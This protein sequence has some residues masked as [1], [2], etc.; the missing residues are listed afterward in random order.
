MKNNLDYYRHHVNSHNHWKFKL[1]RKEYKWE[2][3]G[4]FWALNNEIAASDNCVLDISDEGKKMSIAI[5]LDFD[6]DSFNDYL[7]F[8]STK[9]KLITMDGDKITTK[10]TQETLSEVAQERERKRTWIKQKREQEKS[11]NSPQQDATGQP[12]DDYKPNVDSETPNVDVDIQQSKGKVKESKLKKEDNSL[13]GDESPTL[14]PE[15]IEFNEVLAW[16]KK[17]SPRVLQMKEPLTMEQYFSLK[18]RYG[19]EAIPRTLQ[20][21][22]NWSKL[23]KEKINANLTFHTFAKRE[24]QNKAA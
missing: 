22:H 18:D 16:M 11:S 1:L 4:K 5:D 19:V 3:E 2:G 7:L 24:N 14:T 17:N 9:C 13:F 23:L 15:E 21:M 10:I 6:I 12:K 8:L 20:A